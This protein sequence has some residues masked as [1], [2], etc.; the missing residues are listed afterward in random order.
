[1]EQQKRDCRQSGSSLGRVARDGVKGL[2]NYGSFPRLWPSVHGRGSQGWGHR[3][4]AAARNSEKLVEVA[5]KFAEGVRTVALDV[6]NRAQAKYAVDAAIETFGR[7][8][9]LVNNA[10]YGNA[11]PVEDTSLEEFRAHMETLRILRIRLA[12]FF[13]NCL[14]NVG[15]A[16]SKIA[17]REY[18]TA[19]PA[20]FDR[21][22][23]LCTV[24]TQ[25]RRL[26]TTAAFRSLPNTSSTA[27]LPPQRAGKVTCLCG[28]T[29]TYVSGRS[30]SGWSR[31]EHLWRTCAYRA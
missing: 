3:V 24:P 21:S 29:V 7:L 23:T 6:T 4:V 8:D 31:E 19:K 1:M 9:V 25:A 13:A 14:K 30:Q 15:G 2:A 20:P 18:P 5:R 27:P 11:C 22:Q 17:T 16:F 26:A 12:R 28:T 10:G